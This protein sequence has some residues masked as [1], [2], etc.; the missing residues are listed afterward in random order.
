MTPKFLPWQEVAFSATFLRSIG[1]QD[2]GK[3]CSMRGRVVSVEC[4]PL[5]LIDWGSHQS[6]VNKHNLVHVGKRGLNP[7]T[8]KSPVRGYDGGYKDFS[9]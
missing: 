3:R 8:E 9:I 5:Y 1:W 2:A 4:D 6:Y 7:D